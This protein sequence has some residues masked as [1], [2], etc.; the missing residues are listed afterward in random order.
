MVF[1][2]M[3]S[4]TALQVLLLSLLT[5]YTAYAERTKGILYIH[6]ID[7]IWVHM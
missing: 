2:T 1:I 7:N 5:S 3:W 6:N 4:L